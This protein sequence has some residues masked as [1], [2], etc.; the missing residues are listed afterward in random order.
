MLKLYAVALTI[1]SFFACTGP[2]CGPVPTMVDL[3][4]PPD[5]IEPPDLSGFEGTRQALATWADGETV[6]LSVKVSLERQRA[7]RS[8]WLMDGDV[9]Q[10]ECADETWDIPA[11]LTVR[12]GDGPPIEVHV[13]EYNE[14]TPGAGLDHGYGVRLSLDDVPRQDWIEARWDSSELR[15][16]F[17]WGEDGAFSGALTSRSLFPTQAVDTA[18]DTALDTSVPFE[19]DTSGQVLTF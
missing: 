16:S 4:E 12:F 10:P 6:D 17:K 14:L 2:M 7:I 19:P 18:V 8:V 13:E 9:T 11:N 15:L 5:H 1:G 3:S